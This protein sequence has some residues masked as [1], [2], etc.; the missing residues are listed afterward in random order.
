LAETKVLVG[1]GRS[2]E[3]GIRRFFAA[4][5]LADE[6]NALVSMSNPAL[7]LSVVALHNA[8]DVALEMGATSPP[9]SARRAVSFAIALGTSPVCA[10]C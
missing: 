1:A 4:S 5:K 8:V 2:D 6:T 7:P 3:C 9:P 10:A